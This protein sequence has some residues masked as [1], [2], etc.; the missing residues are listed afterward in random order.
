MYQK[1]IS[2]WSSNIIGTNPNWSN[3]D[4]RIGYFINKTCNK[5]KNWYYK[6]FKKLKVQIKSILS[7]PGKTKGM[8]TH[9]RKKRNRA[10]QK[11]QHLSNEYT[12]AILRAKHAFFNSVN[13]T[14]RVTISLFSSSKGQVIKD[15]ANKVMVFF[16]S[17]AM[18]IAC[19]IWKH[20]SL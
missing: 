9:L 14:K 15:S 5:T 10:I 11:A 20:W 19:Q 13:S 12:K 16:I 3:T 17:K 6:I 8:L 7:K 4:E 1:N 2:K 18:T